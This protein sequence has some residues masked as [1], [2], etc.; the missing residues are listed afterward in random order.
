MSDPGAG[1]LPATEVL[2]FDGFDDLDSVAPLE[3][4]TAAGFPVIPVRVPSQPSTV[5][6]AH[7]LRI[8][9]TEELGSAPDLVL[10][11]GGGWRDGSPVGVRAQCHG[12]L[13]AQLA[14]LHARGTVL[15]SVCTGAMLLSAAGLLE[16]RP[17]V[18]N[19]I[20][21][22]DLERAGTDVRR[23][24]RVVDDGSL[25]TCGGPA[26]GIDLA[27]HLVERFLGSAAAAQAALR[28]DHE[29]VGPVLVTSRLSSE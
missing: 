10:V 25:V 12:D 9:V 14:A 5:R 11:P 20:A 26:A 13:P 8:T 21:L 24:A 15:A 6:S 2:F 19:R 7:G 18:T 4:L 23:E 1:S 22:D 29:P 3:I 27:L 16:G 17:A 28:L